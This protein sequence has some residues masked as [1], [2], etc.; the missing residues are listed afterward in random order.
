[1]KGE[2]MLKKSFLI[3]IL[4]TL[5]FSACGMSPANKTI[6]AVEQY[7]SYWNEEDVDGIISMVADEPEIEVNPGIILTDK[8]RI[9]RSFELLFKTYDLQITVNDFDV[10][11]STATYN[12]Q[13]FI[14]DVLA[15]QGRSQAVIENGKIK[16]EKVIGP[17]RE[18]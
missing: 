16:S 18:P 17:Y 2:T 12:Y 15:E 14:G 4:F 13:L 1:M 3:L 8:E 7:F 10:D 6:A 11:G 5:L 9:R